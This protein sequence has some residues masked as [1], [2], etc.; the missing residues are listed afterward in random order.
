MTDP[1]HVQALLRGPTGATPRDTDRLIGV[2]PRLVQVVLQ[3]LDRLPMFVV[4]GVRT[5]EQQAALYAQG[6]TAPGHLVTDKDGVIRRSNHEPALD[7]LGH[8]VDCA[9]LGPDPFAATH[10]W[11]AYGL[12]GEAAGLIWGGRWHTLVDRPHLELPGVAHPVQ[13]TPPDE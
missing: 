6:R 10:D 13:S 1:T 2:H 12:L 3:I 9:F 7:G 4:M 8:A 5:P 11:L